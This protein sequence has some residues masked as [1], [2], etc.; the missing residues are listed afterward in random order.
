MHDVIFRIRG[1]VF[2]R[3]S[4]AITTVWYF[5]C[6]QYVFLTH[7]FNSKWKIPRKCFLEKKNVSNC[8]RQF[9]YG[10]RNRQWHW[11]KFTIAFRFKS[12]H[13]CKSSL[14]FKTLQFL[15]EKKIVFSPSFPLFESIFLSKNDLKL[16]A[17][18]K[19]MFMF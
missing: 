1:T 4:T 13:E 12:Q 11:R 8:T 2:Q 17:R 6:V 3:L 10:K 15:L 9:S 18:W 5:I 16:N 19:S 7:F 14:H